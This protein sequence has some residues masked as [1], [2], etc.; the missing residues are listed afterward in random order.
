MTDSPE[1]EGLFR[2]VGMLVCSVFASLIVWPAFYIL[3]SISPIPVTLYTTGLPAS[4]FTGGAFVFA[5]LWVSLV[6]EH[7][8]N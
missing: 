3:M 8:D 4:L 1:Q 6:E 2:W 5:G 7:R